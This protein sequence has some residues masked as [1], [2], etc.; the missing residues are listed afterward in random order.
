[1]H[2]INLENWSR[3]EHF[4]VF[5]AW[6]YPHFNMCANVDL[7]AFY[8]FTKQAGISFTIAV[9]YVITRAAN[10]IPEFRTRIRDGN[11][12]QH[13]IVHPSTTILTKSGLFTF[14]PVKY[15]QEFSV[16]AA[17]AAEK[18]AS[19]KNNPALENEPGDDWLYMTAIPWVTFTSFMHPINFPVDS[20][21]RFA[22]GKFF[23]EADLI[24]MPLSVQ[25]H[26]AL[27]DGLHM[28]QFYAKVQEYYHNP[29]QVL[30]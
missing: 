14:C 9:M 22:W 4:S 28:G 5:S 25:A 6:D 15:S 13:E 17:K 16:F 20:I 3:S 10:A 29:G 18:I 23:W 12:V 19:V 21:P 7:T 11:V 1:M 27:M 24:R 8:P 30:S 2:Q 26:H